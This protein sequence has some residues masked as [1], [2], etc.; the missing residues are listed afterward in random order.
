[1]AWVWLGAIGG[2]LLA[3]RDRRLTPRHRALAG[4]AGAALAGIALVANASSPFELADQMVV[5]TA[6]WALAQGT[7]QRARLAAPATGVLATP[8][9]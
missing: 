4:G 9:G 8:A 2:G 6:L 1:M 5:L 7:A 3:L